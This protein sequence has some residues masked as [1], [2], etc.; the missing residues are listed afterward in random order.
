MFFHSFPRTPRGEPV[1][2]DKGLKILA[3]ILKSGLLLVPEVVDYPAEYSGGNEYHLV[4][5]RFC[6]TQLDDLE[7]LERHAGHFGT[8]HLEFSDETIYFLG[9]I[10][11]MYLPKRSRQPVASS[12]PLADL[13]SFFIHRLLELQNLCTRMKQLES[14]LLTNSFNEIITI[15][16]KTDRT[17]TVN[18]K[19]AKTILKMLCRDIESFD[20]IQG[21]IQG[22][23]SLFY[24][25][26]M[27]YTNEETDKSYY[28][29]LYFFRQREWRV[30][31]GIKLAKQSMDE[32][33]TDEE[34]AALLEIDPVFYGKGKKELEFI[35]GK[36]PKICECS[37]IKKLGESPV[38]EKINYI[39]VPT[40]KLEVARELAKNMSIRNRIIDMETRK[41][42]K[43]KAGA[44]KK[45]GRT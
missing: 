17:Y 37:V 40:A 28:E 26:D 2:E 15:D 45:A 35:D 21:A 29:Q 12:A 32:K 24:P 5:S 7:R 43:A 3:N 10:P 11:V 33:L 23:A 6:L 41:E 13:G 31:R 42:I 34:K 38:W 19:Q 44:E 14:I 1:D 39:I 16:D 18:V 36:N 22:L 30:I 8:F 4:Q 20:R 25:V 9:A 27:D